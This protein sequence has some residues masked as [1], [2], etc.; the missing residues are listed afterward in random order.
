MI[1]LTTRKKP[2]RGLQPLDTILHLPPITVKQK[3][4]SGTM[5]DIDLVVS[6]VLPTCYQYM[7]SVVHRRS[8]DVLL[9]L[10]CGSFVPSQNTVICELGTRLLSAC[11]HNLKMA[12]STQ[13]GAA[14]VW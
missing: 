6:S 10:A 14:A 4:I 3:P 1:A 9:V 2:P 7:N 8:R 11:A 13:R 5:H 12:F